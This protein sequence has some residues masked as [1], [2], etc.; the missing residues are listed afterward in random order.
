MNDQKKIIPS[1]HILTA[2]NGLGQ[3]IT[4]YCHN[5]VGGLYL[6]AL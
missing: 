5:M 6:Y 4:N 2:V 1:E 3:V